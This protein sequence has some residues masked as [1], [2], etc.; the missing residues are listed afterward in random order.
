VGEN[1]PRG[2]VVS[3]EGWTG[4]VVAVGVEFLSVSILG[5]RLAPR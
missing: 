3:I 1:G 2:A 5:S 4:L